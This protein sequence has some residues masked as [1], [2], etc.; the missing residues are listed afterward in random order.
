MNSEPIYA[1]YLCED[2][3]TVAHH[4]DTFMWIDEYAPYDIWIV[5]EINGVVYTEVFE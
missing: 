5:N 1:R 4:E 2:K 3:S